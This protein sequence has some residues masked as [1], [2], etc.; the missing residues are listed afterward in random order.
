MPAGGGPLRQL[1]K[2]PGE[3]ARPAFSHDGQSIYFSSDRG[4]RNEIWRIPGSGG[5]T[6]QVTR[7]GGLSVVASPD[8]EWLYYLSGPPENRI[9]RIH[10][11]GSG[12][13]Q[14]LRERV[15]LLTYTATPTGLWFVTIVEAEPPYWALKLLRRGEREPREATKLG[16]PP[17]SSLNLSMS[18]D[19]RYALVTK[20]DERGTDLLLVEHFR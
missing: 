3:D 5:D 2:E 11:D 16:F 6:T 12:D 19:G 1:T 14:V 4:G 13:E 9:R 7:N 15:P 10:P 20:A 8:G 17:G 18:P